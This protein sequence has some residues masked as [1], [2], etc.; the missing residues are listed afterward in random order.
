MSCCS[1][2]ICCGKKAWG[3]RKRDEGSVRRERE[4]GGDEGMPMG[5]RTI[6]DATALAT[7]LSIKVATWR[8]NG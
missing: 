1:V 3:K 2:C 8:K 7:H 4:G 5:K 6:K